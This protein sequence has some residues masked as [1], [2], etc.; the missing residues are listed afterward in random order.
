MAKLWDNQIDQQVAAFLDTCRTASLATVDEQGCPH[1]ANIQYV[2][3]QNGYLYFISNPEAAHS[4]HIARNERVAL[5]IYAHDDRAENIHGVQ[6]RA[7][8]QKLGM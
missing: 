2:R 1:G 4:R 3:D 5:T 8:A 6:M 7:V